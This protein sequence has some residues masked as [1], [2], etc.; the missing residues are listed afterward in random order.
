MLDTPLKYLN[1]NNCRIGESFSDKNGISFIA[2]IK[3]FKF[4]KKRINENSCKLRRFLNMVLKDFN[5][6]Y[7]YY[8]VD[9]EWRLY[10]K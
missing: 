3:E 5:E 7:I 9:G 4:I 2:M 10:E 1:L 8:N 6:D